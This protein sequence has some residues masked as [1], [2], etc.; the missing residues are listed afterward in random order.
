M[1]RS[2]RPSY[3][4]R[5]RLQALLPT[6][7]DNFQLLRPAMDHMVH[8]RVET[9]SQ[10]NNLARELDKRHRDVNIAKVVGSSVGVA[11][12]AATGFGV[13]LTPFT[14]GGSMLLLVPGISAMTLGS[15]TVATAHVA[16]KV[17][18]KV[19]LEKVQ[20]AV[21]RDRKQCERVLQ[22]WKDFESY[23]EDII[24]TI[25]LAD[26]A[27]GSDITSLQ[28]WVQ[29]AMETVSS[30]VCFVAGVFNELFSETG[31]LS[32]QNGKVLFTKFGQ[33]VKDIGLNPSS[34]L[35]KTVSTLFTNISVLVMAAA[36]LVIAAIGVGNLFV[37]ITTS[38]D[39]HRGSLSKVAQDLR[40]K[41]QE[42]QNQ[43]HTWL[44]VFGKQG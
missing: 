27:E 1:D 39:I 28:T 7:Y 18:Q 9:I 17:L 37:L 30:P 40:D 38:M 35:R 36:F 25:T 11:G 6:A 41:A 13:A 43:L 10:L 26:P 31:T 20:Q 19:D 22:L 33:I 14:F 29:V 21:D 34:L 3:V 42:L 24:N 4:S 44:D 16:E 15:G 12:A 5:E 2:E 8:L 23:S 32:T